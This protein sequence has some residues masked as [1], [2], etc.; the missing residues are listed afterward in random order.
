M[1]PGQSPAVQSGAAHPDRT[2]VSAELDI[3]ELLQDLLDR[4]A[5]GYS[6]RL[7]GLVLNA[8]VSI[9]GYLTIESF[10]ILPR[11]I[12]QTDKLFDAHVRTV[13]LGMGFELDAADV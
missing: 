11:L 3:G 9:L 4:A 7:A 6:P 8:W 13:M 2:Q 12:R 1:V 5:P 10:G